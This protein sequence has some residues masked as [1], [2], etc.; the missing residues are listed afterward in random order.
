MALVEKDAVHDTF[1][2][3]IERRVLEHDVRSLATEFEGEVHLRPRDGPLDLLA[4]FGRAGKGDLVEIGMPNQSRPRGAGAGHYVDDS[5][6]E[7]DLLTDGCPHKG[8]ERRRLRGFEHDR[9]ARC[10]GR[11]DLPREHQQWEVPRDDLCGDT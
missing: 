7:L 5:W 4:D 6:G 10:E 3:L 2:R 8:R 9:V 11:R 1:H